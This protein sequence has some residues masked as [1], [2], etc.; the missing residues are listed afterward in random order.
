MQQ[1]EMMN[2]EIVKNTKT[3][4]KILQRMEFNQEQLQ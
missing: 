3:T 2:R 4:A 1:A